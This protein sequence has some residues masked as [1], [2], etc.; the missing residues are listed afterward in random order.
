MSNILKEAAE[1]AIDKHL[2]PPD[3]VD[4]LRV[5]LAGCLTA[6]EGGIHPPVLAKEGDFGYSLAYKQTV[7]LRKR[8]NI[9]LAEE[10]QRTGLTIDSIFRR[11]DIL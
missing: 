2:N 8:F 1:A 5:Q 11:L 7:L 10:Q 6:A 3:P 4:Q 9:L